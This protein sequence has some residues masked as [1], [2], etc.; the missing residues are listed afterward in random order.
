MASQTKG[1]VL[2]IDN[3]ED[4]LTRLEKELHDAGYD[5]T[6]TWS[7]VEAIKL[8]QARSFDSVLV[9][10]YLPDLYIGEFLDTVS[11]L[12]ACPR[13]ILMQAKPEHNVRVI[14]SSAFVVVDKFRI[15]RILQVLCSMDRE[16]PRPNWTH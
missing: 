6:T 1:H 10:D 7:G 16:P 11:A 2:I 13:V 15:S 5:A 4:A 12:P 14:G 9:G 8:L 3:N